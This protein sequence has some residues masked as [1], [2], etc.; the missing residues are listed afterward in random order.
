[1]NHIQKYTSQ[2]TMGK[3]VQLKKTS[4]FKDTYLYQIP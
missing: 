4:T 2:D 1:M 3:V